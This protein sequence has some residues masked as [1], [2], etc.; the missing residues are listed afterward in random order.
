MFKEIFPEEL[1][2]KLENGEKLELIDVRE[3]DEVEEGMIPEAK[4]IRMSEIPERLDELDKDKETIFI[5]RS[6]GRSGN[7]C[8]YLQDKGYN[9]VNMTGGMLAYNGETKP[10][11]AI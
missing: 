5:C 10:K 8:A 7:V 9:V 11:S 4:H 1:R 2:Q 6:G 3:E